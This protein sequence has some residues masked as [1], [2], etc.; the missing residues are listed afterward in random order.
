MIKEFITKSYVF[1][2]LVVLFVFLIFLFL[3]TKNI[4]IIQLNNLIL[5]FFVVPE[6]IVLFTIKKCVFKKSIFLS[7]FMLYCKIFCITSL[8]FIINNYPGKDIMCIVGVVLCFA[9]LITNFFINK[10]LENMSL[11]IS[12]YM[13]II[14]FFDM[15]IN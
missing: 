12:I 15:L 2:E 4:P 6:L 1:R 9:F 8:F 5:F 11:L 10:P 3:Q 13:Q 7:I 14:I